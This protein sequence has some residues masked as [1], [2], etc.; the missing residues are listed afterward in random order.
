MLSREKLNDFL[1][2]LTQLCRKHRLYIEAQSNDAWISNG[3]NKMVSD[4]FFYDHEA[5][6]YSANLLVKNNE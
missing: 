2:E 5:Q 4:S 3:E 1:S 6:E